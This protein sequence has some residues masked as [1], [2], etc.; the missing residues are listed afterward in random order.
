MAKINVKIDTG[1]LL[2][3]L[4]YKDATAEELRVLLALITF[5]GRCDSKEA[6]SKASSVSKPRVASSLSFWEEEGVIELSTEEDATVIY[7]FPERVLHEGIDEEASEKVAD[8]I[9]NEKLA[10]LIQECARLMGRPSLSSQEIKHIAAIYDQY[11]VTP[12][13]ILMLAS[14]LLTK[15]RLTTKK[16][17][18]TASR[19]VHQ[20]IDN[21]EALEVYIT[22][23]EKRPSYVWELCRV[24]GIYERRL[25]KREEEYFKKWVEEYGFST[26]I[27]G[28]AYELSV[29]NT[30]KKSYAYMEKVLKSWHEAGCKTLEDCR[31]APVPKGKGG[32]TK[33]ETQATTPKYAEFDSEDALLKALERS[34]GDEK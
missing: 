7:E 24:I 10:E 11:S 33:K 31:N 21:E 16:L 19:L 17:A 9:R 32:R 18:D 34:Y 15:G 6:L 25:T 13:Y 27:I 2:S 29:D 30:G 12:E 8:T 26:V 1:R 22:N 4:A 23:N 5:G 3:S 14:H 20:Q 28:E